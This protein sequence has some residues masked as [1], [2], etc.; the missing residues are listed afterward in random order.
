VKRR[1]SH[2]AEVVR[3]V[4]LIALVALALLWPPLASPSDERRFDPGAAPPRVNGAY[5]VS[6]AG[7]GVGSGRAVVNPNRVKIDGTLTDAQGNETAFDAPDL[8]MDRSTYRFKGTGTLGGVAL[9]VSGRVDP[10]D[11]TLKKCRLVATF[12]TI[13]GRAGRIAGAHN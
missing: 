9:T 2:P 1:V 6:F 3:D 12:T 5:K 13:D 7:P 8:E 11:K 4:I 10:D